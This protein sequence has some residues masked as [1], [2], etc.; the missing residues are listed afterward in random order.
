MATLCKYRFHCID[1]NTDVYTDYKESAPTVCPNNNTHSM[2]LSTLVIVDIKK[3]NE[4]V[5]KEEF[6]S[7]AMGGKFQ[8]ST[9]DIDITNG[10][11][12]GGWKYADVVFPHPIAILSASWNHEA[13]HEGDEIEFVVAPNLTIGGL[14]SNVDVGVTVIPVTASVIAN[15]FVGA[16]IKL[17]DG[18]NTDELWRIKSIDSVNNTITIETATTHSFLSANTLVEI[19]VKMANEFILPKAGPYTVGQSKI[20]GSYIPANITI[21]ARYKKNGSAT[22]ILGFVLEY[23]Y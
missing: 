9:L 2:D 19:E 8:T 16:F 23:L 14:A 22:G 13:Q 10:P 1:E 15:A 21:R 20:G 6:G 11:V 12:E 18:T 5:V 4:V 17:T 3:D 7:G